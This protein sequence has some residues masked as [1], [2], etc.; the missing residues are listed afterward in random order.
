MTDPRPPRVTV[1]FVDSYCA[2]YKQLFPEV[3]RSASELRKQ[4]LQTI[5][6][7]LQGVLNELSVNESRSDSLQPRSMAA[8][9]TT[10]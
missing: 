2:L 3:R 6:Q 7:V 4:R 9:W 5:L 10:S 1:S 8:S